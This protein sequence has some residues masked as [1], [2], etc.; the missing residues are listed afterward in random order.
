MI[1]AASGGQ[2]PS[3]KLAA[4][5]WQVL[6]LIVLYIIIIIVIT[7]MIFTIM[8]FIIMIINVTLT[9]IQDLLL[10]YIG[11]LTIALFGIFLALLLPVIGNQMII[12]VIKMM[13][14]SGDSFSDGAL[15]L[16]WTMK[17]IMIMRL[18]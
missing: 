2:D 18:R 8:I 5:H 14:S 15:K 17:S 7:I 11:V 4:D 3:L 6:F 12:M 10:Q 16:D 13:V 1:S 9:M